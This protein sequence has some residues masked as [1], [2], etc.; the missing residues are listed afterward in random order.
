M[1]EQSNDAAERSASI[2]RGGAAKTTGPD[3]FVTT[4]DGTTYLLCVQ[5]AFEAG[6]IRGLRAAGAPLKGD[7]TWEFNRWREER[8]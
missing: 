8:R 1:T 7:P 3:P 6:F 4:A 2:V 5:V